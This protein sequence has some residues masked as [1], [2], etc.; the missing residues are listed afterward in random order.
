MTVQ[1]IPVFDLKDV[2][3][4]VKEKQLK[5][6]IIAVPASDAQEVANAFIQAGI[7]GILNFAPIKL[8]APD[9]VHVVAADLSLELQRLAYYIPKY[10]GYKTLLGARGAGDHAP[11][12][13]IA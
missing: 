7:Q 2:A 5:I 4:Q 3:A 9:T 10:T 13:H 8:Q 1:G 12:T 6:V 11:N